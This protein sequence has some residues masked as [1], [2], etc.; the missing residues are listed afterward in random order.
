MA[1]FD[2][3]RFQA[4]FARMSAHRDRL[5]FENR[6]E[7][8]EDL[9]IILEV[10]YV[11][12]IQ[13]QALNTKL[14]PIPEILERMK[15]MAG[16]LDTLKNQV[17]SNTNVIESAIQLIQGIKAALDAAI[18][19]NN[20]G[21]PAAL[22]E[23]SATLGA[24]DTKLA[25]AVAAATPVAPPPVPIP[26]P[27]PSTGPAPGGTGGGQPATSTPLQVAQADPAVVVVSQNPA[28]ITLRNAAGVETTYDKATGA[29]VPV[30]PPPPPPV[31]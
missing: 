28:Q 18:A 26:T 1:D 17:A 29:V 6:H 7:L 10:V 14:A 11:S 4:S 30:A 9:A 19:A 13:F 27:G 2:P 12:F 25:A 15:A 5:R 24:E 21:D 3:E 22:A 20:A 16:E 8:V 31:A 23:L